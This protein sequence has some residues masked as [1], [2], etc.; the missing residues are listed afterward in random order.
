MTIQATTKGAPLNT[1]QPTGDGQR[2]RVVLGKMRFDAHDVGARFIM[3]RLVEAGMEV[4]FVRFARVSELVEAALQEDVHVIG[5]SSL[6]G[7]HLTVGK[8]L[9]AA[10]K[11]AGLEHR[12]LVIGGVIADEDVVK[13]KAMGIAGVFGPGSDADAVVEFIKQNVVLED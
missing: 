4:V 9:I 13:L 10:V 7:G 3:H 5:I 6:T 8:N 11:E 12:L 1:P 2:I